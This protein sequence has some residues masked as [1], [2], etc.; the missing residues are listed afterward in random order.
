MGQQTRG[1]RTAGK[2]DT[3][4]GTERPTDARAR[5]S[6][7]KGRD[8][9]L[10]AAYRAGYRGDDR[11]EAII[12]GAGTS[13][14]SA[15]ELEAYYDDG[16]AA[17]AGEDRAGRRGARGDA[18]RGQLSTVGARGGSIANDGAGFLLGLFAYALLANYLRFGVPG[19]KGWLAAKFINRPTLIGPAAQY[20]KEQDKAAAK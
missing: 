7:A 3:G 15:G 18:L 13:D 8:A 9:P 2:V 20:G 11:Q 19:V 14:Y 4:D 1:S 5:R 16:A 12:G 6:A 10:E 17:K